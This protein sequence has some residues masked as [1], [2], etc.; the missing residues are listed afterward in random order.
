MRGNIVV[1]HF[2]I[3]RVTK[4]Y[5]ATKNITSLHNIC[6]SSN[7]HY[8]GLGLLHSIRSRPK[9]LSFSQEYTVYAGREGGRG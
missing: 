6:S 4:I 9:L 3:C 1:L 7:F 8:E 5:F 2:I